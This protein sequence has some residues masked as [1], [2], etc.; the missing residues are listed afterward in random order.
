M[1]SGCYS[2]SAALSL[3]TSGN[4]QTTL[5]Q[6]CIEVWV[7]SIWSVI[8]LVLKGV[9]TGPSLAKRNFTAKCQKTQSVFD[10]S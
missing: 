6:V 8:M 10:H 9:D 5:M 4:L 3:R 2:A 7:V 1:H